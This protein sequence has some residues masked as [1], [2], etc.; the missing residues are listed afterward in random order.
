MSRSSS[1]MCCELC[2]SRTKQIDHDRSF[3][4]S[5]SQCG[6]NGRT[7]LGT[8]QEGG[9]QNLPWKFTILPTNFLSRDCYDNL[10]QQKVASHVGRASG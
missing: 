2:V 9:S 4:A 8:E 7:R 1:E 10:L 3:A 5:V 6:A